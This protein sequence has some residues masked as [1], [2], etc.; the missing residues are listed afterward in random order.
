MRSRFAASE[1][2]DG[3]VHGTRV[4][5]RT[6]Y[7]SHTAHNAPP[8]FLAGQE[9]RD[10]LRADSLSYRMCSCSMGKGGLWSAGLTRRPLVE[11]A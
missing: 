6:S 9:L 4:F 5:P 11:L 2:A 10:P 7:A 8:I 1:Y 3:C